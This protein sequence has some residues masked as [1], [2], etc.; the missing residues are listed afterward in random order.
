MVLYQAVCGVTA[1]DGID[2][3]GELIFAICT[4][5]PPSVQEQAPW[6]PGD[7]ASVI[8]G[9]LIY[10][11][12]ARYQSAT[13]MRQAI[14]A[15]LPD[16]YAITT[17]ML[18]ELPSAARARVAPK[19]ATVPFPQQRPSPSSTHDEAM[20]RLAPRD[21]T[22]SAGAAAT[23]QPGVAGRTGESHQGVSTEA[24]LS[25]SQEAPRRSR[26]AAALAGVVALGFVGGFGVWA[27]A[28]RATGQE[29]APDAAARAADAPAQG[30]QPRPTPEIAPG[31]A[32]TVSV[33]PTA[34]DAPA[35]PPS[36]TPET[37]VTGGDPKPPASARPKPGSSPTAA[38]PP[39]P[40]PK[41]SAKPLDSNGFGDRK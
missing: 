1:W 37:P 18:T 3:L 35:P 39:R 25:T 16:G 26:Q 40:P 21:A 23:S 36:A 22:G 13:S 29:V 14:E 8:H 7:V 20:R 24:G 5:L 38:V 32:A 12:A 9:A 30:A 27:V 15:L 11:V 19:M 28:S 6:V 4:R 17:S 41:P 34:S 10:D 2:A 31:P 33:A